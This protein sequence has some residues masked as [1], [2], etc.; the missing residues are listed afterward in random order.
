MNA[1][2]RIEADRV[3]ADSRDV[4][5]DFGKQHAHVLRA[6][7]TKIKTKPDLASNFGCKM[8]Q[9]DAGKGARRSA[10]CYDMDRKGFMLL[11]M[12]FSGKKALDIQACWIDAF[13]RMEQQLQRALEVSND[14]GEIEPVEAMASLPV[15]FRDRLRFV[16][17]ARLLGG[18]EAGRRAWRVMEFPDVFV[19]EALLKTF[20]ETHRLISQKAE[21]AGIADW[22]RERLAVAEGYRARLGIFYA[23]YDDWHRTHRGGGAPVSIVTFGKA[24]KGLGLRTYRS[25]GSY[26]AGWMLA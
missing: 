1:L 11:V 4:A 10:R 3:V 20:K 19:P 26:L 14:E 25:D 18:K 7:D 2:V 6:I 17:E 8:F 24:V 12:G 13:D 16:S 22:A 5:A 21:D 15:D 9:I 23:D